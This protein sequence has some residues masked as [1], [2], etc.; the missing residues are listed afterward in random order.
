MAEGQGV[1][2]NILA[3]GSSE[4][5]SLINALF[6]YKDASKLKMI[7]EVI[8]E[9]VFPLATMS[10][11]AARYKSKILPR[12]SKELLMLLVSK[13]RKGRVELVE[14]MLNLRRQASGEEE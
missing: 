13:D 11:I 3:Q 10:T 7:S 1:L 2:E 6:N 4:E 14:V 9:L 12:F 5:S 8:P